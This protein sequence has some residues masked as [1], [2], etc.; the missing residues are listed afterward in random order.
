MVVFFFS[1]V[2][3]GCFYAISCSSGKGCSEQSVWIGISAWWS[4]PASWEACSDLTSKVRVLPF[5]S[6]LDWRIHPDPSAICSYL[7]PA[8]PGASGVHPVSG[9]RAAQC[10][11]TVLLNPGGDLVLRAS[12][13]ACDVDSQVTFLRDPSTCFSFN[14]HLVFQSFMEFSSFPD[15][16][17]EFPPVQNHA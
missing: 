10:G 1:F 16:L 4:S 12:Y 3:H 7:L 13:L 15:V 5:S 8:T 14:G 9:R 6:S 11:Y 17:V 2:G